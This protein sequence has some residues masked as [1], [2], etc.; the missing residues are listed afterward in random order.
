ME[1]HAD[2]DQG[3][4]NSPDNT[5]RDA[6]R[7]QRSS[8][9][10][11]STRQV[12]INLPLSPSNNNNNDNDGCMSPST[13]SR[14]SRF[15]NAPSHNMPVGMGP[16]GGDNNNNN[17]SADVSTPPGSPLPAMPLTS[18][19][20]QYHHHRQRITT[21]DMSDAMNRL[22]SSLVGHRRHSGGYLN[23]YNQQNSDIDDDD[24]SATEPAN[25]S[26][27]VQHEVHLNGHGHEHGN[28][29]YGAIPMHGPRLPLV[30][31]MT[32]AV[33]G[34]P[35]AAKALPAVNASGWGRKRCVLFSS[36][37]HGHLKQFFG[38]VP[39]VII[40]GLFHLMIGIPFGVSYFPIG[41]SS[42]GS[43]VA[44]G[45][46]STEDPSLDGIHGP[47]P[48]PG[49]E[50]LGIRMFLFSTILG[51]LVFTFASQFHNP[52]GL[53]MVE[54][55]PFCHA[56]SAT[57]IRH[58]GY[59][60]EA[61]STLVVMF[62]LSSILVG[63]VFY[64]LGHYKLGRII[65]FF[66]THVL[67][68]CIGGIGLFIA[69]TGIEVTLDQS[70]EPWE[71]E[72]WATPLRQLWSVVLIFEVALRALEHWT[73]D[74]YSLLSPIYFLFMTPIFYA[75]LWIFGVSM[76]SANEAGYFFPSLDDNNS[77][78]TGTYDVGDSSASAWST[79]ASFFSDDSLWEYWNVVDVRLVSWKAIFDSIPT[80]V[81]LTLFSLIHVPINIPAF[82][83]STN[84]EVD[85]NN[86][87]VAHGYSNLL[88][89]VFGGLQNYMA[90]TQS[91][92]YDKSGGMGR[93]SGVAVA[94]VT[95]LLYFIGPKI[96]S[97]IPR[98][99]AGTLLLHVGIDL[100]LE[101][102]YDSYGKFDKL[103][104]GGIWLIAIVMTVYGMD[105]AMMAGVVAAVSTYAV[106]N[107]TYLSPIRG[108]MSAATLRSSQWN[109]N[110]TCQQILDDPLK[111][112]NRILVVQL[113]GHLFF[114][115]MAHLT[116]TLQALMM[117]SPT[118]KDNT[119]KKDEHQCWIVILDFSLVLGIDSS[120]AQAI[121][122]LKSAILTK[123]HIP[124][125]FFVAGSSQGFPCEINLTKELSTH[126][127]S[128]NNSTK[129]SK[130]SKSEPVTVKSSS[131]A[132]F[133][134]NESPLKQGKNGDEEAPVL[135]R[136]VDEETSLLLREEQNVVTRYTSHDDPFS[137]SYCCQSLDSALVFAENALI[138]KQDPN[139][140][141]DDLMKHHSSIHDS[142][143]DPWLSYL[144]NTHH[145]SHLA[146]RMTLEKEHELALHYLISLCSSS[147]MEDV[148]QML[149]HFERQVL[150]QDQFLWRQGDASDS[151]KLLI[152]GDLIARLENEAGTSEYI[153]CGNM[154]GEFGLVGGASRMTSVQCLSEQCILYSLPKDVFDDP[155]KF[156]TRLARLIDQLCV[157]YLGNRVQHVSNRIFETRCLPI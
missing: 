129:A 11:D 121:V 20:G 149:S 25:V 157:Q 150:I 47:F 112:R 103:E 79:L 6:Y 41:W 138:A 88:A 104:Y 31:P 32:A 147:S 74:R 13:H 133:S 89:G 116:E 64:A 1:S 127:K 12:T 137:G 102:V 10:F 19:S 82:A 62:G 48:L 91:V 90:Y 9:F 124:L 14:A 72:F 59:G 17:I 60:T 117:S 70:F 45:D 40:M 139:L 58:V 101:G 5:Q 68:G 152:H 135:V 30:P 39:A 42:S 98:C 54:N 110:H 156:D 71:V 142:G 151:C 96:A 29:Y 61:L 8:S 21:Y 50:A 114:G 53:Q 122:K 15:S 67:V 146:D 111:G 4:A 57:V 56:L 85:M 33:P 87:L 155:S 94:A 92:L 49:K 37:S 2:G 55:V 73:K 93:A 24:G 36:L 23:E 100:F 43:S 83:I 44:D 126:Y 46:T 69:K 52:I 119:T 76:A 141:E 145:K 128:P 51:Q 107:I 97:Y 109:R 99:M 38:Q 16:G 132:H 125:C 22:R 136:G 35:G 148:K 27:E 81:A 144:G 18:G 118:A 77:S 65:Y 153:A 28:E 120:A 3:G 140:L 131:D 7:Q 80:L 95:S 63:V 115:N 84:T 130:K 75:A 34:S 143:A 154:I 26:V 106:Q 108:H 86:E 105:A 78:G 123:Y 66:P 134:I 113:Q